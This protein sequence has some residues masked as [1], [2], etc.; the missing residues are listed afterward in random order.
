[1]NTGIDK[2]ICV[3][4]GKIA[5]ENVLGKN[6]LNFCCKICCDQYE[7]KNSKPDET[8]PSLTPQDSAKNVCIFC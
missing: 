7:K 5:E 3:E 1:M 6:Q 4:C 2:K 8:S